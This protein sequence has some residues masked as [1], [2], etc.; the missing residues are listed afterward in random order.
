ME[1]NKL[2]QYFGRFIEWLTFGIISHDY[3]PKKCK[4]KNKKEIYIDYPDAYIEYECVDCKH[5]L[6]EDLYNN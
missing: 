4:H 3:H 6:F 2:I 5:R 1:C